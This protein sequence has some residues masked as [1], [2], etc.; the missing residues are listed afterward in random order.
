MR[1]GGEK[2]DSN[3]FVGFGSRVVVD[4]PAPH[5]RCPYFAAT[6]CSA[7]RRLASSER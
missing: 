1:V 7:S 4:F 6:L 2:D 3:P 5:L